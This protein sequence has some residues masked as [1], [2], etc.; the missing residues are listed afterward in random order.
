[1]IL[2]EYPARRMLIVWGSM[3]HL[4]KAELI[5]R[6]EALERENALLH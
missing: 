3:E 2:A 6:I 1:M 4:S 5:A